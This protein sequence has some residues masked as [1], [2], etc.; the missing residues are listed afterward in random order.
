MS[1]EIEKPKLMLGGVEVKPV[2]EASDRLSMLIWGPSGAGKSTIAATA[3]GKKLWLQFDSLGTA[4]LIDRDD[5]IFADYSAMKPELLMAKFKT[6]EALGLAKFITEHDID[7]VVVD[8]VTPYS[9]TAMESYVGKERN[10]TIEKPGISTYGARNA[11]TL[12]M[13]Q[14]VMRE[15]ARAGANVIFIAHE[16]APEKNDDGAVL[17]VTMMLGGQLPNQV[18]L[19]I[20]EVWY[21]YEN[22]QNK[23]MIAVRPVRGYKPMKTRMF[24]VS[25]GVEFH[26]NYDV[27]KPDPKYTIEHWYNTW[28]ETGGK[29]PLPAK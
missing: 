20:S 11:L 10:S 1:E 5:I 9:Q 17:Y 12:R 7:T 19:Q 21:M 24:N 22:S 28:R 3:P 4:S 29:I 27:D 8:S 18:A 23:R 13:I 15:T 25:N 6:D 16:A 26:W 14:A 2:S